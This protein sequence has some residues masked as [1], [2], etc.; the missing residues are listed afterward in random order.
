M[1]YFTFEEQ[2]ALNQ[3]ITKDKSYEEVVND[4]ENIEYQDALIKEVLSSL[5]NKFKKL[6][7]EEFEYI[8]NNPFIL[9]FDIEEDTKENKY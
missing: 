4:L 3:I 7:K 6:T 5:V 9:P 1:V 8:K 2:S